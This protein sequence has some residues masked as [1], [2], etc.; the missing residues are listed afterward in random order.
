[1]I[2][3]NNWESVTVN[4]ADSIDNG[5]ACSITGGGSGVVVA[6]GATVTKSYTCTY[7]SMPAA[8]FTNT[9]TATWDG[10]A[11]FTPNGSASGT[12]GGAFSVP[13]SVVNKTVT[14]TDTMGSSTVTLGSLTATDSLP[15]TSQTYNYSRTLAPPAEGCTVQN[16]TAR[17]VQTNQTASAAVTTCG[18]GAHTMGFWQNKNGQGLIDGANQAALGDWLRQFNAFSDA[19][20]SNI[21][22]YVTKIIKEATCNGPTCNKMLRGQM[23]ATALSVY[24]SDAGLGGNG[25]GT[26]IP[27]G[28]AVISLLVPENVSGAF[29]NAGSMSIMDMLLY[30]NVADP[31]ADAGA[32]WYDQVKAI[33]VLA[34]SAF[35][36]INNGRVMSP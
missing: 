7:S 9:A 32:N 2:N 33:Q 36:N 25:L 3:P 27:I 18:L 34:K 4:L 16:N 30:Q 15:F 31:A 11:S 35:D 29:A 24:F 17:I 19:P 20:S 22:N 23:V 1:V 28:S 26:S 12:A 6:A 10:A 14:I 5:G 13:T 21:G 8:A